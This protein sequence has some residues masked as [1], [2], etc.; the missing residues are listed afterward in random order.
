MGALHLAAFL[1]APAALGVGPDKGRLHFSRPAPAPD[2][3]VGLDASR[4]GEARAVVPP[5]LRY[6]TFR[7]EV[8]RWVE[9][10]V[11]QPS[12][13]THVER[14]ALVG[15]TETQRGP[16]YQLEIDVAIQPHVQVVMWIVGGAAPELDRLAVSLNH[17]EAVSVPVDL[18]LDHPALRGAT[19]GSAPGPAATGPFAGPTR[20]E[21]YEEP[22]PVGKVVV[23]RNAAVPLLGLHALQHERTRWAAR[24]TGLGAAPG[25]RSVPLNI[26][27]TAGGS[28]ER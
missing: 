23:R 24:A 13:E 4:V 21:T 11:V 17:G 15:V 6:G 16:L 27:R 9:F 14:L 2:G 26:P 3:G 7:P 8:G 10:D 12:G 5:L 19:A 18:P 28:T 25:L 1:A 22:A 20:V